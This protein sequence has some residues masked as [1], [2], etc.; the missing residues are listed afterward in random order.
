MVVEV[1]RSL[2]IPA[3]AAF[4]SDF[5]DRCE[6]LSR[7]SPF[8]YTNIVSAGRRVGWLQSRAAATAAAGTAVLFRRPDMDT[9]DTFTFTFMVPAGSRWLKNLKCFEHVWMF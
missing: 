9:E 6:R 3:L 2:H 4:R 7:F 8:S 1:A 5:R